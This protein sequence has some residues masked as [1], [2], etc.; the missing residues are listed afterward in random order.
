MQAEDAADILAHMN[1]AQG[2]TGHP[3]PEWMPPVHFLDTNS[4]VQDWDQGDGQEA[5]SVY[6]PM[7]GHSQEPLASD[8]TPPPMAPPQAPPPMF[9]P[10]PI[11]QDSV[12][13]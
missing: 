10:A 8:Q 12:G 2:S 4:V 5:E 13:N 6:Q 7:Q 11:S 9:P 1:E 3:L